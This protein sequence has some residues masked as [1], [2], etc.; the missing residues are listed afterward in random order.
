MSTV[1]ST[2]HWNLSA[3]LAYLGYKLI[4]AEA[5]PAKPHLYEFYFADPDRTAKA[6][7]EKFF[8]KEGVLVDARSV[9][10]AGAVLRRAGKTAKLKSGGTIQ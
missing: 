5:I 10:E 8:S 9:L 6:A 1:Y 3:F 7:V 4:R 2:S